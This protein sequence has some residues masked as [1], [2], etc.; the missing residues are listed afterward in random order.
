MARQ[1]RV[2]GGKPRLTCQ[3]DFPS[4][5]AALSMVTATSTQLLAT[6]EQ[7]TPYG[8]PGARLGAIARETQ[9]YVAG[10]MGGRR[11]WRVRDENMRM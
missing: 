5:P 8:P 9:I 10:P 4:A 2:D 6:V 7:A 1:D 3:M 11:Y